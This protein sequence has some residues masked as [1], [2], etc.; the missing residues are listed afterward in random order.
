MTRRDAIATTEVAP[1]I[2]RYGSRYI[3]CYL[4]QEGGRLTLLDTGL[5]SYVRNLHAA[6]S[7][8][9]RSIQDID[10]I[11]LTHCHIDHMGCAR[12]VASEAMATVHAHEADGPPLRGERKVPIPNVAKHLAKPFFLRYMFGHIMTNGG[13]KYPTIADLKTFNDGETI[14]VPGSPRVIHTPGHTA[15]SSALHLGARRALFSG[16]AL[17]TLDTLTGRTGPHVFTPPFAADYRQSVA[18]LDRLEGV[19]ADV[20]LPGHGEPWLGS[21]KEAT[22]LARTKA[23]R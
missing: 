19:D 10:A 21:V 6:L 1:G 3:N 7:E 2:F 12:K 22:E 23:T 20:T 15:G 5:P 18:S 14:D 11:I 8:M 9:G 4:I 17:V 16:D 13:P